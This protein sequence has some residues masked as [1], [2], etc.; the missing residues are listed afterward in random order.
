MAASQVKDVVNGRQVHVI[1]TKSI[2]QAISALLAFNSDNLPEENIKNMTE[3]LNHVVSG[4]VTYAV[5]DSQFGDLAIAEGDIIG[6]IEDKI[7]AT[8]R[9]IFEVAQKVLEKMNWREKD[10]VTVFYGKDM[11]EEEANQL[12]EWLESEKP[13]IE[14]EM[15]AGQ[16]PLY[17]YILGVE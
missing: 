9:E 3:A 10:I 4:A 6:L 14:V 11:D 8:G 12:T 15:Y 13:D 16:Q 5:R 7:A 2:P 1:P 17:Y